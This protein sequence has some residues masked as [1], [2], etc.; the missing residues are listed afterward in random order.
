VALHGQGTTPGPSAW[1]TIRRKGGGLQTQPTGGTLEP[2]EGGL[3]RG[4][5]AEAAQAGGA[6]N[7]VRPCGLVRK[8]A[9]TQGQTVT[10][11]RRC[12]HSSS[13]PRLCTRLG[14]R[15]PR[16]CYFFFLVLLLLAV[17]GLAARLVV[18]PDPHPHRLHAILHPFTRASKPVGRSTAIL[19]AARPG[20]L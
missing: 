9:Q 8:E 12:W 17:F 20:T 4:L 19:S 11:R 14:S 7:S 1:T 3:S 13:V 15:R 6:D 10:A 16:L 2:G 18:L 5:A